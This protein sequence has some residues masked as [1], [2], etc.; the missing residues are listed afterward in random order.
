M[1]DVR[2]TFDLGQPRADELIRISDGR[3]TIEKTR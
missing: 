3:A 1:A 2:A